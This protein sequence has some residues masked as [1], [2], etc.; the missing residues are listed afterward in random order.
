MASLYLL[1][2]VDKERSMGVLRATAVVFFLVCTLPS[3]AAAETPANPKLKLMDVFELEYAAD[4][5]ISPDGN[6]VVYA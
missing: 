1:L 3:G 4:P 5:Q 2:I 6:S